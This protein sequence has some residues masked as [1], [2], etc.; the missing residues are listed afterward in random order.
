[1][2]DQPQ[3]HSQGAVLGGPVQ[4]LDSNICCHHDAAMR[5]TVTLDKDVERLLRDAMHRSRRGFKQTLN[6]AIRAGL[7]RK[8]AAASRPAFVVK[9]RPLGLRAGLDPAGFNKL[10]DELE[11]DSLLER[12][13]GH[14]RK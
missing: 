10:A 3:H 6:D 4:H 13:R 11:V 8:R 12:G 9:A 14:K 7:T 1:M 5:T 2:E